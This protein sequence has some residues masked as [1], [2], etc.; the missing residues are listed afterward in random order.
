MYLG[1]SSIYLLRDKDYFSKNFISI[2]FKLMKTIMSFKNYVCSTEYKFLQNLYTLEFQEI[3][4]EMFPWY[5]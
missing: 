3:L 2:S 4:Q 1:S 5:C